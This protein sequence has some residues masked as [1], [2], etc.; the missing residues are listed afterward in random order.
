MLIRR[1]LLPC[2]L[3]GLAMLMPMGCDGCGDDGPAE[4]MGEEIDNAVGEMGDAAEEAA[5]ELEEAAD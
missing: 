3:L 1:W 2:F 4:E 5:D